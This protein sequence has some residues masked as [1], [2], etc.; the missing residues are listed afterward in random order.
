HFIGEVE[1]DRMTSELGRAALAGISL[2]L[3]G[4][5]QFPS[6]GGTVTLWRGVRKSPGLTAL[7]EGVAAVLRPTGFKRE[8]RSYS[9]HVTMARCEPEVARER[10]EETLAAAFEPLVELPVTSF[11][12]YSSRFSG[13]VPTYEVIRRFPLS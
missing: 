5:G 13:G 6:A 2:E 7:H 12:L 3:E 4:V 11:C 8:E 10:I 9:P 1:V